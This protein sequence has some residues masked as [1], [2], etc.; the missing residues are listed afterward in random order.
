[1][2]LKMVYIHIPF[3]LSKCI[4]CDFYSET[5]LNL[6]KEFLKYLKEEIDLRYKKEKVSSVYFG[7]G[8][9]SLLQPEEISEILVKFDKENDCEITMEC[10]P[11]D[12]NKEKIKGYLK[13]GVN[14][15][16]LGVQSLNNFELKLLKR[17]HNREKALEAIKILK[18]ETKNFSCDLIVG[19]KG[20]IKDTLI[21]SLSELI[22]YNTPHISLYP[23]EM[24]KYKY[25]AEGGDRKA[26]LLET[27]WKFLKKSKYIHYEISN[28]AKNG[29]NCRH[30]LGYWTGLEYYGFGPSAHSFLEN[31]RFRNIKNLKKYI[32]YLK[33][34]KLPVFKIEILDK[35]K[36]EWEKFIL[37]LRTNIGYPLEGLNK[38]KLEEL[39]KEKFIKLNNNKIFLT[40]KGMLVFNSLIIQLYFIKN[41]K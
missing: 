37:I 39:I 36:I 2:A 4:Y 28:F 26:D 8:T 9:P 6:K 17:R 29:F 22:S 15:F 40:E 38:E 34:G 33:E 7:G 3:C 31:K 1:M 19:I 5:E 20:Q 13:A 41:K 24:K 16:S 35:D 21:D 25:L 23:L 32:I 10:N 18:D 30:N 27:S 11:E 14:R 12:I